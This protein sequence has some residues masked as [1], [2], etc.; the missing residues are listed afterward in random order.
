[1]R[2]DPIRMLIVVCTVLCLVASPQAAEKKKGTKAVAQNV[3]TVNGQDVPL[4]HFRA[5]LHDNAEGLL[6]FRKELRILIADREVPADAL[7][8][9]GFVPAQHMAIDGKLRGLLLTLDP[10]DLGA[11]QITVLWK[12]AQPGATLI[13]QTQTS[14]KK[15]IIKSSK[16]AEGAVSGEIEDYQEA[17]EFMGTPEIRYAV[18]FSA[19]VEN[20]PAITADLRGKA[21]QTSA[22]AAVIRKKGEALEK[23]DLAAARALST[24]GAYRRSEPFLT[25]PQ[26]QA[27]LRQQG[28]EMKQSVNSVS[29]LV[30]RGSR[31]VL[32]FEDKSWATFVKEGDA[33]KSDN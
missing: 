26:A 10:N 20:E 28:T 1:M 29:R 14:T 30:E 7:H 24:E 23:K 16:I 5:H 19:A 9:V 25:H 17:S 27:M 18:R 21:A 3:L 33:W 22:Q 15:D 2:F 13:T 12:P 8:G 32:I 31:A 11:V 4:T 6:N